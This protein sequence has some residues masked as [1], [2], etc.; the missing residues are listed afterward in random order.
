[1]YRA[2]HMSYVERDKITVVAG[3]L[4]I[5]RSSAYR[6]LDESVQALAGILFDRERCSAMPVSLPERMWLRGLP[7]LSPVRFVGRRAELRELLTRVCLTPH[8]PH[9]RHVALCGLPG[10]GKTELLSR[11]VHEPAVAEAFADGLLWATLGPRP[12][13]SQIL[14]E[15]AR[16]L[17]VLDASGSR[18]ALAQRVHAMIGSRRILIMIDDARSVEH[19]QA[20]G[21]GGP[22]CTTVVATCLPLVGAAVAGGNTIRLRGLAEWDAAELLAEFAPHVFD[23][24]PVATYDL[25]SALAGVPG[26]ILHAGRYLQQA[27]LTLQPRR[28]LQALERLADPLFR[29][30]L[31]DRSDAAA[32]ASMRA[33]MASHVA[34][35]SHEG[36]RALG[37]LAQ[38]APAPASF[39]QAAASMLSGLTADTLHELLDAGLLEP[40][41]GDS[42]RML[43]PQLVCDY[44]RARLSC[45]EDWLQVLAWCCS[46]V[47]EC[48][49]GSRQHAAALTRADAEQM[50]DVAGRAFRTGLHRAAAQ[51]LCAA[52]D[53][54]ALDDMT[55]SC[56]D[57]VQTGLRALLFS[58]CVRADAPLHQLILTR[59]ARY[60]LAAAPVAREPQAL[61]G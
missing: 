7:L 1:M 23:L 27:A 40:M 42:E 13:L 14:H 18:D 22:A 60:S 53:C 30:A 57:S 6:L 29:L 11:L 12:D 3:K 46:R 24:A 9:S 20:L 41:C 5:G 59:L 33:A 47:S 54:A 15:W 19:V 52:S 49:N 32:H 4:M 35:L 31:G 61:P 45:P 16:A 17:G 48:G 55:Q 34:E 44:A 39:S 58:D 37:V 8:V 28:L 21:V 10:M 56:I 26:A 51:L 25:L 38:L 2:L 50:V 36:Q 43:L